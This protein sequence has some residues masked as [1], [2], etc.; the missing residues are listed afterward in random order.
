MNEKE[1]IVLRECS[2]FFLY[3]KKYFGFIIYE[4]IIDSIKWLDFSIIKI[5]F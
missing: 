1:A 3:K 2:F 4:I 5:Y